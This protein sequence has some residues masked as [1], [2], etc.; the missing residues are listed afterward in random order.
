M[1]VWSTREAGSPVSKQNV[2]ITTDQQ[3][4]NAHRQYQLQQILQLIHTLMGISWWTT[5]KA[6]ISQQISSL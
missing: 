3:V 4:R 1:G 5:I 6:A 2:K